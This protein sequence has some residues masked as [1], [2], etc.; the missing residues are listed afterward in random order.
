MEMMPIVDMIEE[1]T[2]NNRY[3]H[4][5][6]YKDGIAFSGGDFQSLSSVNLPLSEA[7]G[8]AC[9]VYDA[10]S[11]YNAYIFCLDDHLDRFMDSCSKLMFDCPY[12]KNEIKVI[13]IEMVRRTG[14]RD[15]FIWFGVTN[16]RKTD[17]EVRSN[18]RYD[19]STLACRFYATVTSYQSICTE[20]QRVAGVDI[21][22]ADRARRIPSSSV[23]PTAKNMNA[24]DLATAIKETFAKGYEWCVVL[25][26]AGDITEA[27]GANIF[28]VEG[29]LLLTP[30]SGCLSGIT[31]S[32]IIEIAEEIGL[33]VKK[34]KIDVDQ[35]LAADEAFL[36]STGGGV[37]PINSV[38]RQVLGGITGAGPI[39]CKLHNLYWKK[40]T[41]GWHGSYI[42]PDV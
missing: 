3:P 6:I 26:D 19:A 17:A 2:R 39:S 8:F 30:E 5:P 31:S 40:R 11:V 25:N 22:V 33:S 15:A 36:T 23:D 16:A 29:D 13:L 38:N 18:T 7:M 20:A 27:P 24:L 21:H 28:L 12:T 41:A 34:C 10:V 32:T 37:I 35:L 9:A 4:D 14:L 1:N 42:G